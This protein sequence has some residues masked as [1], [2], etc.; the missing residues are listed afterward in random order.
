MNSFDFR[1]HMINKIRSFENWAWKDSI[2]QSEVWEDTTTFEQ[3]FALF[4]EF[5]ND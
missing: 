5:I 3:W 2:E 4:K 1:E